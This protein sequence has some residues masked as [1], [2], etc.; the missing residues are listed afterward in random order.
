MA[1]MREEVC[2]P[3]VTGARAQRKAGGSHTYL[4]TETMKHRRR[5]K[6]EPI[7]RTAR[8]STSECKYRGGG[9]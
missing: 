5:A 6:R 8:L 3:V 1:S 4:D 2:R 9:L 7:E